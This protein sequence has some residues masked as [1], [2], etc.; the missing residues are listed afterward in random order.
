MINICQDGYN[1]GRQ[2]IFSL[3]NQQIFDEWDAFIEQHAALA[4]KNFHKRSVLE[5]MRVTT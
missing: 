3:E 1:G 4:R 2:Y 5:E